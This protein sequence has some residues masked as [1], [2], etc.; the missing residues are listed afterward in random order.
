[1][2]ASLAD[3]LKFLDG[4]GQT[5]A[6]IRNI[7][8]GLTALGPPAT[9]PH[10]LKAAVSLMLSSRQPIF[11]AWGV[12]L[13]SLYN[14]GYLPIMG[15]KHPWALGQPQE[16]VWREVWSGFKAINDLVLGGEPQYFE[17]VPFALAGRSVHATSFISYSAT[18][19]RDD[20]GAIQGVFYIATETTERVL[21][22]QAA[23]RELA[24]ERRLL[25]QTPGFVCILRGPD[26]VY[27]FVNS[28]YDDLFARGMIIGKSVK[29]VFPELEG[30]GYF[31]LLDQ[32]YRTGVKHFARGVPARLAA[33]GGKPAQQLWLD[34]VYAPIFDED[35]RVT[36][37]FC[38]GH[39][40]TESYRIQAEL[41]ERE[42]QLRLATEAAEVGLWDVDVVNGTLF[43][44]AR[45]K[46]MF[47]IS[48]DVAVSMQDFYAGLHPEDRE[49]TAAAFAAACDP[50]QR[51]LY[52][53]EYRTVGKEDG[54]VRW[55]AAKGR[56]IFDLSGKCVRV[57]GTAIDISQRKRQEELL[58]DA[59]RRKDEF[60]AT[61]SHELRNPLSPV[62]NGVQ[63]L[64]RST[65]VDPE[66]RKY[67]DVMDRQLRHLVHLVDD[68][69]DVSRVS[70][71]MLD[72][73]L[74][75]VRIREV[76]DAASEQIGPVLESQ[77]QNLTVACDDHA[78]TMLVRG[79]RVRLTQLV[80]N[81]LANAAK[82][83]P[84]GGQVWLRARP[85]D[86][87]AVVTVEDTGQ[88]FSPEAATTLFE[89]FKRGE[90]STGLGIG[91]SLARDLARLHD[92][93]L[94]ASSP[95]EGQG[96][97]FTLRVPLSPS[98]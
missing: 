84:R 25:Q 16:L 49:V 64:R 32:V 75:P 4:G 54:V 92:G 93:S 57:I 38:N 86:G 37:V 34:F 41:L 27:D 74:S 97:K 50:Q 82:Y 77:N 39:E 72:L 48:A 63:L 98:K 33:R 73:Q 3:P 23:A 15:D 70:R 24:Y 12:D 30:Q 20:D 45:V 83:T 28:A 40:V 56:G 71:G 26:H 59:D 58:R 44:P 42:E 10:A 62:M 22:E 8:W 88:G 94:V 19:L 80:G 36:G 6:V 78:S 66:A 69:L 14:D 89:M 35:G 53:V 1:M 81:L 7:D 29:A 52:D 60:I 87:H 68:L 47:G 31:E 13:V 67:L 46:A 90:N 17:N 5:G 65:W 79:D 18:P 2:A 61:L 21:R 95:G 55:V 51:A 9:W 11:M 76:L 91:L 85:E 96:A 43:W